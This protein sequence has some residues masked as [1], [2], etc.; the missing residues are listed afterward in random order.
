MKLSKMKISVWT[1][2]K[3]E[4]R[5]RW[6]YPNNIE[7]AREYVVRHV[8][9][10]KRHTDGIIQNIDSSADVT[11]LNHDIRNFKMSLSW[12]AAT[13]GYEIHPHLYSLSYLSPLE[14]V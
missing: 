11:F 9:Q 2:D 13:P 7:I 1:C 12:M 3:N 14:P 6:S 5:H 8:T 10:M 4:E